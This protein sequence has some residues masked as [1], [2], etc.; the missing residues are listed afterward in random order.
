MS[1]PNDYWFKRR[2]YGWGW[3]PITW[4]GWSVVGLYILIIAAG[5]TA[6]TDAPQD[7]ANLESALYSFILVASTISLIRVGYAKGP[8]PRWRWGKRP[9][10]NPNEDI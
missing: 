2:R 10:D 7:S 3:F 9:D 4:Q 8:V 1:N 6:F 5:A